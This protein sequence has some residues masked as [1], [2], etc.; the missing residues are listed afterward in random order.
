METLAD[1]LDNVFILKSLDRK[2]VFGYAES[3]PDACRAPIAAAASLDLTSLGGIQNVVLAGMGGSAVAGDYLR[4]LF[5]EHGTRPFTT[6]RSYEVPSWVDNQTLLICSSYSGNTEETVSAFLQAKKQRAQVLCITSGGKLQE[7]AGQNGDTVVQVPAGRPPR[8][9][10]PWLFLIPHGVVSRLGLLKHRGKTDV[11]TFLKE[12]RKEW[13]MPTGAGTNPAKQL[14]LQ[15]LGKTPIIYGLGQWQTA[16]ACRWKTQ[17]NENAKLPAFANS[18]P[19]LTHNEILGWKNANPKDWAIVT[20]EGGDE[21]EKMKARRQFLQESFPSITTIPVTAPGD[22]VLEKMLALTLLGDYV[23]LYL[24]I[25]D[26]TNPGD[27][28]MLDELKARLSSE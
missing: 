26:G 4:A 11:V 8:F 21:T 15:L 22:T 27:I 3:F 5:H 19:E 7:L 6:S 16:V 17:I 10:F 28:A 23:S 13:G 2:N 12:R 1:R 9:A 18:F 24:A 20:L 14:A 25:L